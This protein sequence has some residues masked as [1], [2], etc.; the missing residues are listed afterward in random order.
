MAIRTTG[1]PTVK[2][3]PVM[4]SVCGIIIYRRAYQ[5]RVN[6]KSIF[7]CSEKCHHEGTT[8]LLVCEECGTEFRRPKSLNRSGKKFCSEPCLISYARKRRAQGAKGVCGDCGGS[9]TKKKYK[10]CR[11]CQ[12]ETRNFRSPGAARKVKVAV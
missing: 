5:I 9:T 8:D 3:H 1:N 12:V 2:G 4:C 7:F 11:A 6:K 10:R